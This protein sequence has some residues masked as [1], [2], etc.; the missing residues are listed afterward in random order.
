MLRVT[1]QNVRVEPISE[2]TTVLGHG[3]AKLVVIWKPRAYRL[4]FPV[5]ASAMPTPGGEKQSSVLSSCDLR[6]LPGWLLW[7][8]AHWSNSG[9]NIAGVTKS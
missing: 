1:L 8:H 9:I 2:D 6:E 4:A 7:W 3:G 5:L